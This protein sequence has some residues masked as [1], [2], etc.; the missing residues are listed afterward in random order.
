MR[1]EHLKVTIKRMRSSLVAWMR[2]SLVRMRS[3]LMVRASDC[4]CTSCNSPGSIPASVGTVGSEGAADEACSVEY[5]IKKPQTIFKK[6]NQTFGRKLMTVVKLHG[7]MA[8]LLLTAI[9][10]LSNCSSHNNHHQS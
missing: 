10:T 1:G 4:Q 2:S 9:I 7:Y 5:S 3:S 8:H 6:N